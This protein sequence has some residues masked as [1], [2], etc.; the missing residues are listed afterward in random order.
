ML[1]FKAVYT[2]EKDRRDN[3]DRVITLYVSMKNMMNVIVQYVIAA[4]VV[5]DV[6]D[7]NL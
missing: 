6:I 4:I 2:L 1:A 3:D 7:L 5:C